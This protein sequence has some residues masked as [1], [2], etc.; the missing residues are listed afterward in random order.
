MKHPPFEVKPYGSHALLLEWPARVDSEILEDILRFAAYLSTNHLKEEAWE[1]IP[2]YHTLTLI[3]RDGASDFDHIVLNLSQWYSA[4]PEKGGKP[5]HVW[6]LPVCYEG[7]YGIDLQETAQRL[8]MDS[9]QL[10][11]QHTAQEYRVYG[12]GFLPGFLYLGGVPESLQL[13]RRDEPRLRVPKGSVGLAGAQ[14]GIYPQ[15]SPGG[16]HII[17]NCP[18]PLFN[19]DK[20]P[21]CLV[22]PGDYIRFRAVSQAEYDLHKLESEVGI[23][24]YKRSKRRAENS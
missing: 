1:L 8:N 20:D 7:P 21:P 14:T 6:E 4:C 18:V 13:I 23:Y 10:I 12:I 5:G 16:W 11:D 15:T 22:E 2:I 19:A 3:R 17:G 9:D 24:K